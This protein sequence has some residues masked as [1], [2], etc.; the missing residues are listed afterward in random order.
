MKIIVAIFIC[1]FLQIV[2]GNQ[3]QVQVSQQIENMLQ[4]FINQVLANLQEKY[5]Q[6][7]Q[8]S[9]WQIIFEFVFI[10]FLN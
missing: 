2:N 9:L 4:T 5:L 8:P 1:S 10:F 6:D 3:V 7:D